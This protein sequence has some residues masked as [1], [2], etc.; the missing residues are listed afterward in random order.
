MIEKMRSI[1]IDSS[2]WKM[3]P[4]EKRNLLKTVANS[5]DGVNDPTAFNVMKAYLNDFTAQQSKELEKDA[6]RCV[7][8][9]I[10]ARD[11]ITFEE[12]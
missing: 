8:L 1:H 11:M 10:K 6:H 3:T 4:E 9:A 5:L 2:N 7:V 12:L